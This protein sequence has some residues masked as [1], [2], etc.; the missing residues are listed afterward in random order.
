MRILNETRLKAQRLAKLN[1]AMLMSLTIRYWKACKRV[2]LC[3]ESSACVRVSTLCCNLIVGLKYRETWPQSCTLVNVT[4]DFIKFNTSRPALSIHLL[5]SVS[6][7]LTVMLNSY[8]PQNVS[9]FTAPLS[10]FTEPGHSVFISF[11]RS[12]DLLKLDGDV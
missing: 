1:A 7:P 2:D 10:L 3:W 4:D 6:R 5:C 12:H 11:A 9:T 8:Y